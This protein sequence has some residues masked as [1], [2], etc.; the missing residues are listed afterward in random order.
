MR[1]TSRTPHLLLTHATSLLAAGALSAALLTSACDTSGGKTNG[2]ATLQ[3]DDFPA[4]TAQWMCDRMQKCKVP[5]DDN[6]FMQAMLP[7]G[8]ACTEAVMP[9]MGG[10][11][12]LVDA[13]K[14]GTITYDP[15]AGAACLGKVQGCIW[16]LDVVN[17]PTTSVCADAFQGTVA[18]GQP[19]HTSAECAGD[20]YCEDKTGCPGTCT[21]RK[22]LGEPCD[23]DDDTCAQVGLQG[24]GVCYW[25]ETARTS[26]CLEAR[27]G[28]DAAEGGACGLVSHEGNVLTY[29]DCLEGLWCDSP[30]QDQPGTCRQ[31]VAAGATCED[32]NQVC[33]TGYA[34]IA[35][36]DGNG[37]SCQP[38]PLVN[39]AGGACGE[40]AFCNPFKL[41]TCDDTTKTCKV[42]GDGTEGSSCD[43]S[44][45]GDDLICNEGLGCDS[46]TKTCL[47]KRDA[48]QPCQNDGMCKSGSCDWNQGVC[49]AEYCG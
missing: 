12:V 10:P 17:D 13:I 43:L 15:A 2:P 11:N 45:P 6:I 36:A 41:L 9:I 8:A 21:A 18:V 26:T 1:E 47:P 25:D 7:Q 35:N 49:R 27:R 14:A 5:H 19:C 32:Q 29:V 22:A 23:W 44:E 46:E 34:C 3:P 42:V 16:A 30:G 24:V 48:G 33:A 31:P 28:A 38:I 39:E 40:T 20:A 4:A 37:R